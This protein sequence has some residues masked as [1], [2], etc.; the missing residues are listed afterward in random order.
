M[1]E[2]TQYNKLICKVEKTHLMTVKQK[3][4]VNEMQLLELSTKT[5]QKQ[6]LCFVEFLNIYLDE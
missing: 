5:S 2:S 6:P 1:I 4:N 3:L